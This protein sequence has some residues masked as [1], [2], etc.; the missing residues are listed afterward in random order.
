MLTGEESAK[1]R[2]LRLHNNLE[3]RK[4]LPG[5]GCSVVAGAS[6]HLPQQAPLGMTLTEQP[7]S[8]SLNIAEFQKQLMSGRHHNFG[9]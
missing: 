4:Q 2:L 5:A 6:H 9:T 1:V 8:H 7:A 3:P